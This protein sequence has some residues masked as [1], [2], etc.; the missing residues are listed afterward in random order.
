MD[1][2]F[3]RFMFVCMWAPGYLLI[4]YSICLII[5][6]MIFDKQLLNLL[7]KIVSCFIST[8]KLLLEVSG[9]WEDP[10]KNLKDFK[11]WFIHN[12]VKV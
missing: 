2:V 1:I 9:I 5:V 3:L 6:S 12:S 4:F 11:I 8:D 7:G 10:A